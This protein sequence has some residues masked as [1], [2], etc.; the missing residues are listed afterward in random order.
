LLR[1][2]D[3]ALL[4]L[5]KNLVSNTKMFT[6][7]IHDQIQQR[8]GHNTCRLTI[9]EVPETLPETRFLQETGF[10]IFSYP[11]SIESGQSFVRVSFIIC[12]GFS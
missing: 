1:C 7:I 9:L 12:K 5:Y 10:L 6:N 4:R 11:S 8:P 3:V 2:R